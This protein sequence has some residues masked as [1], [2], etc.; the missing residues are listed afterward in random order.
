[1]WV[2]LAAALSDAADGIIAKRFN[3]ETV[4]G[5]Y[6]DPIA[7]K[8]L[9]VSVY[10]SLGQQEHLE[11]WLVIMVVFRDAVIV[12]GALLFQTVTSSLTMRPLTISKVNTFMQ[13][14]LAAVVLAVDGYRL[15][16]FGAV[17]LL[18][19]AVAVTTVWSGGVYVIKWS[20]QAA[21]M[22][23]TAETRP[24]AAP[25]AVDADDEAEDSK[26]VKLE[27]RK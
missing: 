18:A 8:A 17:D 15:D 20:Q 9:L 11:S 5:A 7:D 6:L 2:F 4:F 13:L 27:S 16:D 12:G 22:E 26:V 24:E 21:A 1:F 14:L 3:A 19:Y 10:V 25:A 23:E